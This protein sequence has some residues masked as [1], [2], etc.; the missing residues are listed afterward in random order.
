M[1]GARSRE[2]EA[3]EAFALLGVDRPGVGQSR[4]SASVG[5]RG[6]R[7][8]VCAVVACAHA[9]ARR[10]AGPRA[11]FPAAGPLRHGP[12][13]R[14][15][16][17]GRAG[18]RGRA[19]PRRA[20]A[21]GAEPALPR[22]AFGAGAQARRRAAAEPHRRRSG[23]PRRRALLRLARRSLARVRLCEAHALG[24]RRRKAG[25]R[26]PGGVPAMM[27]WLIPVGLL[28]LVVLGVVA[29]LSA[30][31]RVPATERVGPSGEA[32]RNPFLAA[33]RLAARM[34]LR[35]R[36]VRALP[37]FDT[38][39]RNGVLLMPRGRQAI[40]PRRMRDLAGWVEGGGHLIA[41][42][43]LPGMADP[44]LD[45]FGILRTAATPEDAKP[46]PVDLPG[47]RKLN[48]TLEIGRA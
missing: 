15:P 18:H 1:G 7:H 34:G 5:P 45:L 9:A 44:L 31:E 4:R 25:E 12:R 28:A 32:R 29:F 40:E 22:R 3:G 42:A 46:A 16:A 41:E 21:R 6:R 43:E 23:A 13:S 38:L 20:P 10:R 47:G 39:S 35:T 8:R 37:D 2:A 27:R 19:C 30:Y 33:E 11:L 17:A 48:V 36:H 26:L 24:N 14:Q